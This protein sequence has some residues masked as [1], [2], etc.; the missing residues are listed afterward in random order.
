MCSRTEQDD[1][2]EITYSITCNVD[3]G[4][5]A[6]VKMYFLT[7]WLALV[8]GG[9]KNVAE[10]NKGTLSRSQTLR[11]V[12]HVSLVSL[13]LTWDDAR[14]KNK[15]NLSFKAA[16][17]LTRTKGTIHCF[18]YQIFSSRWTH[19]IIVA[20]QSAFDAY[21]DAHVFLAAHNHETVDNP[22]GN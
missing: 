22:R 11:T 8:D 21:S 4:G 6:V 18:Q 16:V 5:I 7:N 14:Q 19:R 2:G 13:V 17:E 10:A 9:H 1:I 20:L 3:I 15:F 12:A